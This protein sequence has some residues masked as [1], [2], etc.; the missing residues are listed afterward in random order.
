MIP[1]QTQ[2]AGIEAIALNPALKIGQWQE[3]E[4]R[5]DL[6][7]STLHQYMMD[8]KAVSTVYLRDLPVISFVETHR[9]QETPL[10]RASSLAAQLNQLSQSYLGNQDITLDLVE[11]APPA[12]ADTNSVFQ[13]TIRIN[14]RELVRIDQGILLV[15]TTKTPADAA[16]LATNR[17]RRLLL[18]APPVQAPPFPDPLQLEDPLADP[19]L[20]PN[21]LSA[22][23][24]AKSQQQ[25]E[26]YASW[27]DPSKYN[28][29][30]DSEHN[31]TAAHRSLPLG[32]LVRVINL[33]NGQRTVVEINGRG[34]F[35]PGRVIDV[36]VA[37]AE[38]LGMIQAGVERVRI[39]V[40]DQP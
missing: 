4:I 3:D 38:A 26:G 1:T 25:Q 9:D 20:N 12:D 34:P 33:A 10:L 17:L 5:G 40:L 13:Y 19:E 16:L 30:A 22:Y 11:S 28:P 15:G 2:S 8:G 6:P 18:N 27:F 7:V 36:S 32:T 21:P 39:E 31:F 24:P 23:L 35:T 29:S 37:A 14:D